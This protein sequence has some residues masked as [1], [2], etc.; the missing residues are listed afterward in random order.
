VSRVREDT[1]F[2]HLKVDLVDDI[3][4][5]LVAEGK[6]IGVW[7]VVACP[8]RVDVV[9]LHEDDVLHHRVVVDGPSLGGVELV[10]VD[11]AEQDALA[12]DLEQA[13][14]DH[15][16]AEANAE[17]DL[18]ASGQDTMVETRRLGRPRLD[19]DSD[20]L[21]GGNVDA[22][23]R[24]DNAASRVAVDLEGALAGDMVVR[25]VHKVVDDGVYRAME[26]GN[27]AELE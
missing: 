14:L 18:F 9:R 19:R 2:T 17:G 8:D 22:E 3:Q 13:V 5:V 20:L 27:V 7:R 12:V 6:K 11:A 15:D 4:A 24:Q 10:P 21:A 1:T 23:F 16:G 26:K 25:G